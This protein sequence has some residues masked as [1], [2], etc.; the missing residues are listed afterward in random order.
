GSLQVCRFADNAFESLRGAA[1]T[2]QLRLQF[3][4]VQC[5]G[6][7]SGYS[8]TRTGVGPCFTLSF[9]T[10]TT[11]GL[12]TMPTFPESPGPDMSFFRQ[13]STGPIEAWYVAGHLYGDL[14][15]GQTSES[16]PA[17]AFPLNRL[18]AVPIVVARSG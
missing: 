12:P 18:V 7:P 15:T 1:Q 16:G 6:N 13:S 5:A 8:F 3:T 10:V 9:N 2:R 14:T 17:L 4:A 11:P